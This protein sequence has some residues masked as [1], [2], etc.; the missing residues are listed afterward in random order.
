MT[1]D[2]AQ[3]PQHADDERKRQCAS[4]HNNLAA[5]RRSLFST[6]H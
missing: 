5:Q 1:Q 6:T 3:E 4:P 2:E